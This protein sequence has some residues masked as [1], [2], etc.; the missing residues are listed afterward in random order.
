MEKE[1]KELSDNIT[2]GGNTDWTECDNMNE[3]EKKL[4]SNKKQLYNRR[5]INT[6]LSF[7][8]K[9][10]HGLCG[11]QNLGN[12]CFMNSAIQCLSNSVDLTYYFLTKQYT[13]E[14]N[15]NNKLGTKGK[16][17]HAWYDLLTDLWTENNR[18]T[19]PSGVKYAVSSL[20]KQVS[21]F[22]IVV[23]WICPTRLTRAPYL[24]FRRPS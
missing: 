3:V 14:I 15:P 7:T 17:A 23:R 9:H 22:I 11:L 20:N 2:E 10:N 8:E 24:P 4:K 12:T 19:S 1:T 5:S 6:D 13:G 18:S 21:I 16:L